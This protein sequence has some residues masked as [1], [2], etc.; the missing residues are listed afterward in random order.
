MVCLPRLL[1]PLTLCGR[2]L[3]EKILEFDHWHA[4]FFEEATGIKHFN[5]YQ[6]FASGKIQCNLVSEAVYKLVHT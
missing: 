1:I 2:N 3:G 5:P 4:R 6:L